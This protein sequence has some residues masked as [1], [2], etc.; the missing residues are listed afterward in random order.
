MS[1]IIEQ[2][3]GTIVKSD[4]AGRTRYTSQYKQEVLA[5]FEGSGLSAPQFARQCGIK[6]PTFAAWVAAHGAGGSKPAG[7]SQPA[8][9]LAEFASQFAMALEVRLPGGAVASVTGTDQ[10][11][12]LAEL[13]R[14]LA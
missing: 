11:R 6:Y 1:S 7:K 12:L 10:I 3:T 13:L 8:F 14:Q 9:L 5:A 4:R 2:P